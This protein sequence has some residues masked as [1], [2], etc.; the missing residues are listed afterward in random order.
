MFDVIEE[1]NIP[2]I[3]L[4]MVS[5]NIVQKIIAIDIDYSEWKLLFIYA[6]IFFDLRI[7]NLYYLIIISK[8]IKQTCQT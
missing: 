1:N 6:D 7:Y 8:T 3:R 2:I 4:G 5:K